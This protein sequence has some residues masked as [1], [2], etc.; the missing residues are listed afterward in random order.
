MT[1]SANEC[2]HV[3]SASVP[4]SLLEGGL[5][6]AF[7]SRETQNVVFIGYSGFLEFVKH[8]QKMTY[9]LEAGGIESPFRP[10]KNLR[11]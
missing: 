6:F 5:E 9:E 8:C 10:A 2:P 11:F 7:P 1:R 4:T 3:E